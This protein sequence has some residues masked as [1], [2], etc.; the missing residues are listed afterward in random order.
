MQAGSLLTLL[1]NEQ[2]T[3]DEARGRVAALLRQADQV[4]SQAEQLLQYRA[5]YEA[6]W[7]GQFRQTGGIELVQVYQGF[8][9]RLG[10]AITQQQAQ[11]Q[12]VEQHVAA[13][14]AHLAE[15]ELRVASVDKL[16]ERRLAEQQRVARRQEQRSTDEAAART[17]HGSAQQHNSLNARPA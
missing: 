8:M 9:N 7:A 1:E 6:R 13:A 16:I 15:C 5:E 12:A 11:V 4:R 3:R 10:Q 17:R 2:R 14:Q